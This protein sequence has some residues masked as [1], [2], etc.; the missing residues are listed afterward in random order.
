MRWS[1]PLNKWLIAAL[2]CPAIGWTARPPVNQGQSPTQAPAVSSRPAATGPSISPAPQPQALRQDEQKKSAPEFLVI[3]DPSHGGA[4]KGGHADKLTEKE[5][6]LA[7]ARELRKELDELGIASLLL[8]ETDINLPLEKR[9]EITNGH[10]NAI[11]VGIHAGLTGQGYRIYCATL[12]APAAANGPFVPW[13]SAQSLALPRSRL[14]AKAVIGEIQKKKLQAVGLNA[15][16]RPLNNIVPPAIAIELGLKAGDTRA[17][18]N[19]KLQN[20]VAAAVAAGIA[21]SRGQ[22]GVHP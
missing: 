14:L 17:P 6:T 4:D 5:V 18:E 9:A 11:Y 10:R 15:P 19:L 22:M 20:A 12:P 8:R 21:T 1:N 16:L 3:I 13:S 7:F 2:F